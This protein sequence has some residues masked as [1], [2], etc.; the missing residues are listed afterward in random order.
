MIT[1]GVRCYTPMDVL[2]F[3]SFN[4]ISYRITYDHQLC[5]VCGGM[6]FSSPLMISSVGNDADLCTTQVRKEQAKEQD[7]ADKEILESTEDISLE[8]GLGTRGR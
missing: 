5:H 6:F 2:P 7:N 8:E 4:I 3:I 1:D